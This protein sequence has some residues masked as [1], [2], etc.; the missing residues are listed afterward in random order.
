MH[1]SWRRFIR[2]GLE[3]HVCTINRSA[4][5]SRNLFNDPRIYIYIYIHAY[6]YMCVCVC[7]G[8]KR[9]VYASVSFVV[10][11]KTI[12]QRLRKN[13]QKEYPRNKLEHKLLWDFDIQTDH[14]IS[15]R[16]PDLIIIYKNKRTCRI[17][18]FAVPP[19]CR[20]KLK[21]SEKKDRYLDQA[22]ELK[23]Y[24]TWKWCLYQLYM[25]LLVQSPKD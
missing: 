11:Y 25:V 4:H 9:T 19:D 7:F 10:H 16:R 20:V 24:G 6:I 1:C 14:L 5:T 23:N 17:V 3:F 12:T 2:R 15:A 22:R 21:G 13:I 18:N 8:R